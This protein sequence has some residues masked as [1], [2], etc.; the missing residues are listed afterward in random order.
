MRFDTVVEG[1]V[2]DEDGEHWTVNIAGGE[3]LHARCC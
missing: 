2:W 1:A 3:R